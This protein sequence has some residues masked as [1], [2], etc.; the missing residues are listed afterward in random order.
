M[1]SLLQPHRQPTRLPKRRWVHVMVLL[2]LGLVRD[3]G[4][5]P[6]GF[7]IDGYV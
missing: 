5:G 7:G 1:R 6:V 3:L 2:G 4:F